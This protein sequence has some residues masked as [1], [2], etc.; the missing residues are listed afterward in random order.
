MVID[1]EKIKELDILKGSSPNTKNVLFLALIN[2]C[3]VKNQLFFFMLIQLKCMLV[4][5][6]AK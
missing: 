4:S 5:S 3:K 2:N 6:E 1:F